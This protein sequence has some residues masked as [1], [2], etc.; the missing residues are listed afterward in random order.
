MSRDQAEERAQEEEPHGQG[1][2]LRPRPRSADADDAARLSKYKVLTVVHAPE[3]LKKPTYRT[4]MEFTVRGENTSPKETRQDGGSSQAGPEKDDLAEEIIRDWEEFCKTQ[5]KKTPQEIP[6]SP[7]SPEGSLPGARVQP[8]KMKRRSGYTTNKEVEDLLKEQEN[9]EF[10]GPSP[11][12]TVSR[13]RPPSRRG[14]EYHEEEEKDEESRTLPS[15]LKQL[16]RILLRLRE[17]AAA[18]RRNLDQIRRLAYDGDIVENGI[19]QMVGE[20]EMDTE[21]DE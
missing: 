9:W 19:Q 4:R 10:S 18:A 5:N 13:N 3:V 15:Y 12:V 8:I 6:D 2:N 21:D 7:D 16:R 20:Q 14:E 11:V 1:Y 17:A